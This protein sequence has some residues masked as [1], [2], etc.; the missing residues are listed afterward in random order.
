MSSPSDRF[1]YDDKRVLVVGGATGMTRSATSVT[2]SPTLRPFGNPA[3]SP[4]STPSGFG[5]ADGGIAVLRRSISEGFTF[6][7]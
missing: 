2:S 3:M 5:D 7:G 6:G 4:P 1:R